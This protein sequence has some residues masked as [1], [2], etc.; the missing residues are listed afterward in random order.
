MCGR[1]S[2]SLSRPPDLRVDLVD[3]DPG[4]RY[5][6][7]NN[8][9]YALCSIKVNIYHTLSSGYLPSLSQARL[10]LHSSPSRAWVYVYSRAVR[11]L[12]HR[13]SSE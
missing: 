1:D 3:L 13:R 4:A 11:L 9:P 10:Q 12:G 5:S 7:T 8:S 2:V 6:L